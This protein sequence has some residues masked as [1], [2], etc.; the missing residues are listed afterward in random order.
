[1]NGNRILVDT[2][3]LIYL[4][5]GDS[6]LAYILDGK[7]IYISFITE[8]ELYGQK[9]LTEKE[10]TKI[11]NVLSFCSVIDI[12]AGIKSS[13]IT[14]R[15]R[16]GIKLPDCIIAATAIYLG[17]PLMTA[18]QIFKKIPELDLLDYQI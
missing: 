5:D 16:Q 18:D 2:N 8:L 13:T 3:I 17:L 15:Q 7:Q 12:N 14:I 6:K 11:G 9:T 1:M 10:K 4:M